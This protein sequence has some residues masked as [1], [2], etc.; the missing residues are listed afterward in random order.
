V[1]L[2]PRDSER[3]RLLERFVRARITRMN[4][5][6]VGLFDFDWH[7]SIYFFIVSP[8]EQIYLR[9]GGR[10]AVSADSYLDLDSFTLALRAVG[11]DDRAGPGGEQAREVVLRHE[12]EP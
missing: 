7:H 12:V 3:G 1:V 5:I 6:D 8:D 10:D 4:R 2:S 11:H 9:Y